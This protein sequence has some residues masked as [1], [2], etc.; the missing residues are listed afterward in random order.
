MTRAKSADPLVLLRAYLTEQSLALNERLPPERQLSEQLGLTRTALRKAMEVLESEGQVWRHVGRGTFIGA[1][2]VLNLKEVQ[3]L[4]SVISPMQIIDARASIEPELARLA[5]LRGIETDLIE[6]RLCHRRCRDA[7]TWRVF[8]AWDNRFHY[9]IA[10]A[11]KNKL[12]MTLFE[13]LNAARRS[14]VWQTVRTGVGPPT[15]Y[16]TF[17]EHDAIL[18]AIT[19]RNSHQA[20]EYMRAHLNSVGT[21]CITP[22]DR[23]A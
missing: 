18:D 19:S 8:E 5:S 7:N 9:A 16:S 12:L 13:T 23:P 4:G 3:Y 2:S 11:T 14:L 21:R 10:A 22:P 15:G 6:I 1:R 17:A 20:A